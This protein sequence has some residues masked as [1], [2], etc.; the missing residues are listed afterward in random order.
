MNDQLNETLLGWINAL[1]GPLWDF[2]VVFLVAVG[3]FYTIMT[4]AVQIRLF[5]H[6]MKVMKNSRGKV[7][8]NA[9][10][11]PVSGLCHWTGKPGR[12]G[13]CRGC[14]HCDC[15]W[16]PRCRVLDVVYCLFGHE[17]CFC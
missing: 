6:S 3:I 7:Q 1:N 9:R 13:Q 17:F 11:Y 16:W 5:W 10:H 8:D 15:D 4:G 12:C 14:R 2:L